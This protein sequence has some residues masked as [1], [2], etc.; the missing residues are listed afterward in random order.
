[1]FVLPGDRKQSTVWTIPARED[2][3]HGHGTQKPVEC[4]RRPMLNN[5][6][7]G[8]AVYD[9]F[10]GSGT[11]IIAA[12]MIGRACHAI[13]LNPVY[14]DVAVRRWEA[15]T[16][17]AAALEASGKTFTEVAEQR[18]ADLDQQDDGAARQEA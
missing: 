16:G 6:S 14:V 8:Q 9:P 12:E 18:G 7:A 4:M 5:S 1:M 11:S 17:K 2:S 13:E 15:F 10:V 3:G